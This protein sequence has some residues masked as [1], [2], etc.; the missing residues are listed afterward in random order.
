MKLYLE[1]EPSGVTCTI[2]PL[3]VDDVFECDILEDVVREVEGVPVETWKQYGK[4]AIPRG[5]YEVKLTYSNRFK[6]ITPQLI[7][8]SGFEGIRIHPGNTDVDTLGCLLPGTR[9]GEAV[10]NSRKAYDALFEKLKAA[11]DA[12]EPITM[13]VV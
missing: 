11:E 1:R 13:E 6:K 7:N 3:Y 10:I 5:T 8:V 2:S 9:S 4:T 12:G